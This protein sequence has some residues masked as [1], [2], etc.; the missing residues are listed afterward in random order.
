MKKIFILIILASPARSFAGL[1]LSEVAPGTA[2]ADWVEISYLSEAK[3]SVDISK[4]YV[5]MYYGANEPL[6]SSPVTLYPYDRRET[7]WDDR[8]AVV[9]LTDAVT[10][11]ETDATGDTNGNGRLDLYCNN[12]LSSLW[13][14]ECCAA[15]DTN[16]DPSDGMLDFVAWSD[17]EGEPSATIGKYVEAAS[18]HGQWNSTVYDRSAS[19][20]LPKGGVN[21]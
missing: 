19:V 4:L 8:F 3:G 1:V 13:N 16:D 21:T 5:T 17:C 10:P 18:S 12:Y 11:D 2:G 9:H 14:G 6:S 7:P 20:Q 15:L